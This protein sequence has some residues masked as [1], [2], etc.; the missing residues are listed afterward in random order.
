[1]LKK[2][3]QKK[4]IFY[5]CILLGAFFIYIFYSRFIEPKKVI[6]KSLEASKNIKSF[7]YKTSLGI[8][9]FQDKKWKWDFTMDGNYSNRGENPYF[10][11]ELTLDVESPYPQFNI[12]KLETDIVSPEKDVVY[13]KFNNFLQLP[14]VDLKPVLGQWIQ[15]DSRNMQKVNTFTA[16]KIEIIEAIAR[17]SYKENEFLQLKKLTSEKVL[18]DNSYHYGAAFNKK[19]FG[20]FMKYISEKAM[21]ADLDSAEKIYIS[22]YMEKAISFLAPKEISGEIWIGK[23]DTYPRKLTLLLKNSWEK[24]DEFSA[25]F[26]LFLHD[27]NTKDFPIIDPKPNITL[28]EALIRATGRD[29]KD[30]LYKDARD[31]TNA[32]EG[33]LFADTDTD[34]DGLPDF[35]EKRIKTDMFN[36]DSDGDGVKDGEE[37]DKGDNPLGEGKLKM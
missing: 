25:S 9:I 24:K 26:T 33:V 18:G 29:L 6:L 10:Q 34:D 12:Q 8:A 20:D 13:I 36:P 19:K 15:L 7:F 2:N 16:E 1:M 37:F 28:D 4:A 11:G 32:K 17:N 30:L 21:N 27:F 14:F 35:M 5:I 31:N 22:Q 3:R 23:K